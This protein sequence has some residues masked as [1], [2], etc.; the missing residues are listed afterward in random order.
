MQ[1]SR[2]PSGCA[3]RRTT[4]SSLAGR[5][6]S[7]DPMHAFV[8]ANRQRSTAERRHY[9]AAA[10]ASFTPKSGRRTTNRRS[11][12]GRPLAFRAAIAIVPPQAQ[13]PRPMPSATAMA[14]SMVGT[15]G[16]RRGGEGVEWSGTRAHERRIAG[17]PS[18]GDGQ[19]VLEPEIIWR[20]SK[21]LPSTTGSLDLHTCTLP[22]A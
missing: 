22:T 17:D 6:N 12:V 5:P 15:G 8:S 18:T 3:L 19:T 9:R 16:T 10:V 4:I 13:C 21:R 14:F 2:G 7:K 20:R 11:I 1:S